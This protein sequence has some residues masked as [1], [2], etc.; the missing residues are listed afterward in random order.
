MADKLYSPKE[1]AG[2]LGVSKQTL[3]I[4]RMTGKYSLPFI[5]IGRI[6]R[7]RESDLQAFLN[8]RVR[9]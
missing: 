6:I 2:Y 5:K 4:W 1:A 8:G 9:G 7:Y 3:N